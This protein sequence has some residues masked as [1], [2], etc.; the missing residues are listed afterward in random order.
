MDNGAFFFSIFGLPWAL[1]VLVLLLLATSTIVWIAVAVV[2]GILETRRAARERPLANSP[3][4]ED[5][6]AVFRGAGTGTR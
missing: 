1:I 2:L 5:A 3:S 4:G 6:L